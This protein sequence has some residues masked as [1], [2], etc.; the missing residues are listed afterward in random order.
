MAD[1]TDLKTPDEPPKPPLR[2]NV[3]EGEYVPGRKYTYD[4]FDN[5]R[6]KPDEPTVVPA[7]P[8]GE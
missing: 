1:E 5:V 7:D 3:T 4:V 6:Q 2:V 8:P